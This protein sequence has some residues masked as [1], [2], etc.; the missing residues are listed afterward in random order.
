MIPFLTEDDLHAAL[1]G[2]AAVDAL[3]RAFAEPEG[4]GPPRSHI[5]LDGGDLLLMPAAGRDGVGVKLVTV[6]PNNPARDLP[7]IHGV[8]VL[9]DGDTL[10]PVALVDGGA[11]TAV[12]TAA[13]S[14]L[15]TRHLARPDAQRLVVFGAGTQARSHIAAM[16]AV[17]PIAAITVVGRTTSSA[18]A[19]VEELRPDDLEVRTGDPSAVREADIICTCTTSAVPVLEGRLLP[20]GVHV[21]AVGAYRPEARELDT[22][23]VRR[24]RV[25]VEQRAAALHEAGDLLIP[26]EEGA[27]EA[28]AIAADLHEVVT[29]ATVRRSAEDITVFKSV[30]LARED[31]AV[32]VAA[33]GRWR[34]SGR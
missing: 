24:A 2:L 32:A 11:L 33:V 27:I 16:R 17:R 30:G 23:A 10:Q 8:Y 14:A 9:F 19:L 18:H 22:E 15:A 29:G 13:V 34:R 26:I 25:V 21:N 28:G 6:A 12:R 5:S 4:D 31:L 20:P 1:P 3:A 7:L